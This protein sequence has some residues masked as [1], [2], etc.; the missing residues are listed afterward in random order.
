VT[1]RLSVQQ[2]DSLPFYLWHW[3]IL[4]QSVPHW[5]WFDSERDEERC[6]ER[7][8]MRRAKG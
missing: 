4:H 2:F 7:D 3:F 6:S 1:D 8:L 5:L